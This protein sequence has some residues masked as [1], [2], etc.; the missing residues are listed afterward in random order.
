MAHIPLSISDQKIE[1]VINTVTSLVFD[2]EIWV[3]DG[4]WKIAEVTYS[5]EQETY[6][7]E[8]LFIKIGKLDISAYKGEENNIIKQSLLLQSKLKVEEVLQ[9]KIITIH[10]GLLSLQDDFGKIS[11]SMAIKKNIIENA[12]NEKLNLLE[13]CILALPFELEKA[14]IPLDL[15]A[16]EIDKLEQTLHEIDK[17]LFGGDV[18][19]SPEEVAM[20]HRWV[21]SRYNKR[22]DTLPL[23]VQN[24]IETYI[25]RIEAYLPPDYVFVPKQR[26]QNIRQNY[27]EY[28]LERNDYILAFN[29]LVDAFGKMNHVIQTDKYVGSISDGPEGVFFP[30]HEKF[31]AI[32]I[33]HFFRLA[34]HEIETHSL[35]D[36]N[37]V[38]LLGNVRG[39]NSTEKDEGLAILMELFFVYGT[40]IL[41]KNSSGENI[42]DIEKITNNKLLRV[43][44]GEILNDE[45][46]KDFL[47]VILY[48]D[49]DSISTQERYRRL[50]RNNRESV[51]HKDTSYTRGLFKSIHHI[52]LYIN[53][54]AKEGISIKDLFIGKISFEE[55]K[56]FKQLKK[57]TGDSSQDL[58]PIF[59]SDAVLYCI[60]HELKGTENRISSED[61]IK[62]LS[63]KYPLFDFIHE[64]DKDIYFGKYSRIFGITN[65]LLQTISHKQIEGIF[66]NSPKHDSLKKVLQTQYSGKIDKIH[67]DLSIKRQNRK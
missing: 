51:Q 48:I 30:I 19:D 1:D 20:T 32:S 25:K 2:Q 12:L 34:M 53:S 61:F 55:T 50:K 44:M 56:K 10:N 59:V 66:K 47:E 54:H 4:L 31:D 60:E 22:K 3:N 6:I 8:T 17:D 46:L 58:L 39:A 13:Y 33:E 27:F 36:H 5:Y 67:K 24:K 43:L 23:G 37:T 26:I 35:T 42:I 14:G 57:D 28:E 52:N 11:S 63:D 9:N 18:K 29:M 16:S 7:N 21:L 64:I 62:Y 45:E 65:I 40:N 41:T 15:P 38:Q 49:N